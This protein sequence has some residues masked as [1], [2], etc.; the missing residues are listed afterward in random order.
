MDGI[1]RKNIDAVKEA[2]GLDAVKEGIAG[3]SE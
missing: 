3:G 1:R 2:Q